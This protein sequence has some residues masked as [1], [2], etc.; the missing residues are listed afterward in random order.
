MLDKARQRA[1]ESALWL[2]YKAWARLPI[3]TEHPLP[4]TTKFSLEFWALPEA[5]EGLRPLL[6]GRSGARRPESRRADLH[7]AGLKYAGIFD[8]YFSHDAARFD[9]FSCA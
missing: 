8:L 1:L 5:G 6:S 2:S 3:T 7:G 4:T 9:D